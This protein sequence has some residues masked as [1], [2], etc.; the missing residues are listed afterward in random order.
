VPL[1]ILVGAQWGDEGKGKATDL[2]ARHTEFV[3]RYQGGNNAGHTVLA[4]GQ[5]LKLHLIPS[6]VL[7]RHVTPVIADGVVVDPGVLLQEMDALAERGIDPSRLVVSGNAHLIMPYH[8]ELDK[9]TERYLGKHRLGTTK[10]GIGPAYA[11]KATRIGL[12]VQDLTDPSIFR[13]KLDVVLKEK[14]LILT[15]VYNRLPMEAEEIAED[16]LDKGRRLG[17]HI[18]DTSGLLYRA[19]R[20]GKRVLLEGAQG[21]LLDLDHG[22]YPFVTSS[23]PVAGGALSGSGLGPKEVDAVVGVAKAYVTRVGSGPFPT[24]DSGTAGRQMAQAGQEV[25]TT[26][27]RGRRCGWLDAVLLRYAVRVNGLTELFVTKLDVLSG[28]PRVKVCTSYRF[29]G[30]TYDDFPPHQSIFHKAEARYEELDGWSEDL[31]H[32]RAFEDLPPAARHYVD[33]IEE[34]AGVPVRYLS[35]GPDRDQTLAVRAGAHA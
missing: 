5:L 8:Q 3:V 11:D 30:R 28:L 27:G 32:A 4:G 13:E 7:Y 2:L 31:T 29:D 16:Y 26:T 21:T 33:R 25:G 22:T 18:R 14:N 17:P 6:G 34:L 12:R 15:K 10:R 20:D 9:L 23:S 24:E 19:L 1:T 35:V